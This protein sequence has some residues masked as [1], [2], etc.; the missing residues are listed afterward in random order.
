MNSPYLL[1]LICIVGT[2]IL[3]AGCTTQPGG[4]GTPVP[5]TFPSTTA[6]PTATTMQTPVIIVTTGIPGTISTPGTTPTGEMQTPTTAPGGPTSTPTED[7][8]ERIKIKAENFA[9][10]RSTITV[11]AGSQVIVEFENEDRVGHNMAFYTSPSLSTLI[12][13]GEIITGPRT[14]IYTFTAPSTPGTYYFHC[15]PHPFMDGQFIVT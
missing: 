12:Y 6:I 15:D 9:F 2:V 5:T 3:C 4:E 14:I 11:A 8:G 13:R 1:I 10:D 7:H